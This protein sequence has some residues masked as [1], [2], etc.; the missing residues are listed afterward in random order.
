[1]TWSDDPTNQLATDIFE[2]CPDYVDATGNVFAP[3]SAEFMT[4]IEGENWKKRALFMPEKAHLA[5]AELADTAPAA[6]EQAALRWSYTDCT[7]E[8]KKLFV[9]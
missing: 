4:A 2:K 1:L 8:N 9:C 3:E 6:G 5:A 7:A